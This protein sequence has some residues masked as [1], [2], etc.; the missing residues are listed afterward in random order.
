M[1]K[2]Q[3]VINCNIGGAGYPLNDFERDRL[4]G[5]SSQDD[6]AFSWHVGGAFFA[7]V[8]G[9]VHWLSEDLELGT[10]WRLGNRADGDVLP[11]FN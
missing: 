4:P 8:D 10:F 5:G 2:T 3:D 6:C 1:F 9:S 7:Y 11:T